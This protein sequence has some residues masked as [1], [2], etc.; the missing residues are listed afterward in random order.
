MKDVCASHGCCWEPGTGTHECYSPKHSG[1]WAWVAGPWEQC[2]AWCDG[3][4]QTRSISCQNTDGTIEASDPNG[5]CGTDNKPPLQRDC[6][7]YGTVE[8]CPTCKT[9]CGPG[10]QCRYPR[11]GDGEALVAQKFAE[12]VHSHTDCKDPWY[13]KTMWDLSRP[14]VKEERDWVNKDINTCDCWYG[15]DY[16]N[17]TFGCDANIPSPKWS[18][19]SFGACTKSCSGSEA[20]T[21]AVKLR[22]P[23]CGELNSKGARD[24]WKE[25]GKSHECE[26]SAKPA[27]LEEC[28]VPN[29]GCDVSFKFSFD[30]NLIIDRIDEADGE[31][32]FLGCKENFV[33]S[34][35]AVAVCK[36][37]Q[38]WEIPGADKYQ[39]KCVPV[40]DL[41]YNKQSNDYVFDRYVLRPN[42]LIE[43][44]SDWGVETGDV[45]HCA[46]RC[47]HFQHEHDEH[48]CQG[49]VMNSAYTSCTF[50]TRDC[51]RHTPIIYMPGNDLY[52][53]PGILKKPLDHYQSLWN[54]AKE[55]KFD[56]TLRETYLEAALREA[57]THAPEITKPFWDW[58]TADPMRRKSVLAMSFPPHSGFL[59]NLVRLKDQLAGELAEHPQLEQYIIAR[60]WRERAHHGKVVTHWEPEHDVGAEAGLI[61][62]LSGMDELELIRKYSKIL[63]ACNYD[64]R[65]EIA[66]PLSRG[67]SP[68][69]YEDIRFYLDRRPDLLPG[70]SLMDKD[71]AW[72]ILIF[73]GT[74]P[75]RECEQWMAYNDPIK[76]KFHSGAYSFDY[77]NPGVSCKKSNWHPSSLLRVIE[78][79]GVCGRLSGQM[80]TKDLCMGLGSQMVGQPRHAAMFSLKKEGYGTKEGTNLH[81]YNFKRGNWRCSD[82]LSE[83]SYN[84]GTEHIPS[85]QAHFPS[86]KVDYV[87]AIADGVNRGL[88]SW[89]DTRIALIM[90]DLLYLQEQNAQGLI[91]GQNIADAALQKN[92]FLADAWVRMAGMMDNGAMAGAE[93]SEVLARYTYFKH[94]MTSYY[95][96][97]FYKSMKYQTIWTVYFAGVAK[98]M[99]CKPNG[100]GLNWLLGERNF[101]LEMELG[102]KNA[103][104]DVEAECLSIT[105]ILKCIYDTEGTKGLL[106][107]TQELMIALMWGSYSKI[108]KQ[109]GLKMSV[110][111]DEC[112]Y[113][114]INYV[115]STFK[116][117]KVAAEWTRY[118]VDSAPWMLLF[119]GDLSIYY[120]S[121]AVL[122]LHV[123][124][125]D[126]AGMDS[127][128]RAFQQETLDWVN[129][130]G[131]YGTWRKARVGTGPKTGVEN[132]LEVAQAEKEHGKGKMAAKDMTAT[133]TEDMIKIWGADNKEFAETST[134]A[135][136]EKNPV[137]DKVSLVQ[138]DSEVS[139][140]SDE[141]QDIAFE[142]SDVL[143]A[144]EPTDEG[145]DERAEGHVTATDGVTNPE[146]ESL[147][148]DEEKYGDSTES[149]TAVDTNK[150]SA[151]LI[152][153]HSGTVVQFKGLAFMQMRDGRQLGVSLHTLP[154]P[155]L[156]ALALGHTKVRCAGEPLKCVSL[157]QMTTNTSVVLEEY[158]KERV[159]RLL[160]THDQSNEGI[161]G[162][163]D[164]E[165]AKQQEKAHEHNLRCKLVQLVENPHLHQLEEYFMPGDAFM[166][167]LIATQRAHAHYLRQ[168]IPQKD[169]DLQG[170]ESH[171]TPH[172]M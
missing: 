43:C 31:Y 119:K 54:H 123:S 29:C 105:P 2:S 13:C 16:N 163:E 3:G 149:S 169:N 44:K 138:E 132:V 134:K 66:F 67:R 25:E 42:M 64:D 101:F 121:K 111:Y 154:T 24:A 158:R 164:H 99:N 51:V 136:A 9:E 22:T 7:G 161:A 71:A 5:V 157:A 14:Q 52:L 34:G 118:L 77:T 15:Y 33:L 170:L 21:K 172:S 37:G 38:T 126:R 133:S 32:G 146:E 122:S 92:P 100:H 56:D 79:G 156:I 83:T 129:K 160:Y 107:R 144:H 120:L 45:N 58:V 98:Q 124:T 84:L 70:G 167:R 78:D 81:R 85:G 88:D 59:R 80:I 109:G 17:V 114:L 82:M 96:K 125:L 137:L 112:F 49:F 75:L 166:R 143:S 1:A 10:G 97:P 39:P 102:I 11:Q 131:V 73:K 20:A 147:Q 153:M 60:S 140:V 152:Q 127:E 117:F 106:E 86:K 94:L 62:D 142:I 76:L 63:S 27:D 46:H 141:D 148:E 30:D 165:H 171:K 36:D 103:K 115:A 4:Q 87:K 90:G 18:G 41:S 110:E 40:E 28:S 26:E 50:L 72:P 162:L 55:G 68:T 93:A 135:W 104:G 116:D 155:Q 95:K 47:Q 159:K 89:L 145:L 12:E 23:T 57:Q 69:S 8:T 6:V 150:S 35:A 74:V 61:A 53:L 19:G 113:G 128:S 91:T 130:E 48:P 151:A 139:E 65:K 168:F 108:G